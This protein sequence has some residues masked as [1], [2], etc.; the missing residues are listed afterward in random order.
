MADPIL[1]AATAARVLDPEHDDPI[2]GQLMRL[3]DVFVLGPYMI[4]SARGVQHKYF[5]TG[6]MLLGMGTMIYNGWNLL[7][8]YRAQQGLPPPELGALR[9][10]SPVVGNRRRMR[11]TPRYR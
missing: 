3:A 2:K 5:R 8:I 7:R 4:W 10:R 11:Y 9:H 1:R 6:L